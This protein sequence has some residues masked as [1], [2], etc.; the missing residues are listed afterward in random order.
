MN[1]RCN[2]IPCYVVML[3]GM[4]LL[5]ACNSNQLEKV[6]ASEL[7]T[8]D[9]IDL[10]EYE[11]VEV[12]Q[13]METKFN[14]QNR[15]KAGFS[16]DDIYDPAAE[17]TVDS[18]EARELLREA[19]EFDKL[20]GGSYSGDDVYDPAVNLT[21]EIPKSEESITMP[22]GANYSGDDDYDPSVGGE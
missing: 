19:Y 12:V 3:I 8:V 22:G 1:V 10:V 6:S 11:S 14:S 20:G 16:G 4:I 17:Q 21:I 2:L 5:A 7:K 9:V 18:V 15:A 13:A